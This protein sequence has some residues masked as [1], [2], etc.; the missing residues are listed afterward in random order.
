MRYICIILVTTVISASSLLSCSGK[1]IPLKLYVLE[2]KIDLAKATPIDKTLAVRPLEFARPYKQQLSYRE[3]GM[4]LGHYQDSQWSEWP[5]TVLARTLIQALERTERFKDVGHA[6]NMKLPDFILNGELERF[7]LDRSTNPW[8][9]CVQ[10]RL[11]MRA[12][13][14]GE[15]Y[16]TGTV[17]DNEPLTE[18]QLSALPEAM[19]T[20]VAKALTQAAAQITK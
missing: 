9:A 7:D 20:A 11:E 10:I 17:S 6:N 18:N 16:W 14:S 19:S 2:P 1:Y 8:T 12:A 3:A 5:A 13:T 15:P 4:V